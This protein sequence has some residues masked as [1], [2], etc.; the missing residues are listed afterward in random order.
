M[1]NNTT[2]ISKNAT[3]MPTVYM[4]P[5]ARA[6]ERSAVD[7]LTKLMAFM[8]STGK[9][10]GI[11]L[12]IKPPMNAATIAARKDCG[13]LMEKP[14]ASPPP[15]TPP[16]ESDAN[17]IVGG[18]SCMNA[19]TLPLSIV[20]LTAKVAP[21]SPLNANIA[22]VDSVRSASLWAGMENPM[23]GPSDFSCEL[24]STSLFSATYR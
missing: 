6:S 24:Y 19:S 4:R 2:A 10:H 18:T 13:L 1:D 17:P 21:S 8:L 22:S 7:M 9:T 16:G 12:R 3:R 5:L 20:S 14:P 11:A 15:Y 23:T